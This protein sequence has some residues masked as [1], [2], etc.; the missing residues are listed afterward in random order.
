MYEALNEVFPGIKQGNYPSKWNPHYISSFILS[1]SM[2][3]FLNSEEWRDHGRSV[4]YSHK[5]T[6]LF[7]CDEPQ[8]C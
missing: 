5:N 7:F 1:R 8:I 3:V 6:L 4:I 2:M